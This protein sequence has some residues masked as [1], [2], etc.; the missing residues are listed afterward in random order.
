MS[1]RMGKFCVRN[2][3][4]RRT[5]GAM[6]ARAILLGL[7]L[8]LGWTTAPASAASILIDQGFTSLDPNT[9]LEWLDVALTKGQS[10]DAVAG[11]YGGYTTSGWRFATTNELFQL[12]TDAGGSGSYLEQTI[13]TGNNPTFEAAFQLALM[14]GTTYFDSTGDGLSFGADGFLADSFAAGGGIMH[15]IGGYYGALMTGRVEGDLGP[16]SPKLSS[17]AAD[18]R[19]SFLVRSTAAVTAVTPLPPA[20][21]LFGTALV[22]LGGAAWR[23]RA[24]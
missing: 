21:L 6:T 2:R 11:G 19:G 1:G 3:R 10:Y 20:L 8:A 4:V 22:G 13:T 5:R 24:G 9:H 15:S 18:Y 23:R 14:L 16:L 17:A 12:F 7:G